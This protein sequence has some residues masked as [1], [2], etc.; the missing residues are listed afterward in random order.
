MSVFDKNDLTNQFT[1]AIK[2]P[3]SELNTLQEWLYQ[4]IPAIALLDIQLEQADLQAVRLRANFTKNRNHHN[5]MFGRQYSVD[6]DCLWLDICVC[7]IQ[8]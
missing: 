3:Q 7:A 8:L 5:T 1:Q 6:S 2:S 4:Q